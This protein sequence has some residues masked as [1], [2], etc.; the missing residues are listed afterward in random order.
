M[1][2]SICWC[3]LS[4]VTWRYVV[5]APL[6]PWLLL[7]RSRQRDNAWKKEWLSQ[8]FFCDAHLSGIRGV[9]GSG[10]RR[11]RRRRSRRFHCTCPGYGSALASCVLVGLTCC[12]ILY[13]PVPSALAA[14]RELRK[15]IIN[16]MAEAYKMLPPAILHSPPVIPSPSN[17][18]GKSLW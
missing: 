17:N 12:C 1:W 10:G 5:V 11:R 2:I 18:R 13:W 15:K 3:G 7:T 6:S 9:L 16:K 4:Y 8:L 14:L